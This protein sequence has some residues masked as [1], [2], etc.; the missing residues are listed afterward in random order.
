[1]SLTELRCVACGELRCVRCVA[2]SYEGL[3]CVKVS[4]TELRCVTYGELRYVTL[5]YD[6]YG[7]L[8]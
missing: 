8:R 5:S 3:R 2:V 1:V 6:T 4:L 7:V